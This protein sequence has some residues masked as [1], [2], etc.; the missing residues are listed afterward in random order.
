MSET[1]ELILPPPQALETLA[2]RLTEDFYAWEERG[3]GWKLHPY[4]IDLEPP[5]RP[6][7]FHAV[8][9][10]RVED[11][12]RRPTF[13]SR[14]ADSFLERFGK[15]EITPP[16]WDGSPYA[17]FIEPECFPAS[18]PSSIAEISVT[19][20]VEHEIQN[21]QKCLAGGF[22]TVVLVSSEPKVLARARDL[23]S[24]ALAP[25]TLERVRFLAPEDFLTFLETLPGVA[26]ERK[27]V[28]GYK[29]SVKLRALEERQ[30]AERKQAIAQTIVRAV[31]RLKG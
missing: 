17:Q 13:L 29:V 28:R 6:F 1:R 5:F 16:E 12:A 3:R 15:R 26:P 19:T 11:D 21:V 27:L 4:P 20:D 24:T 14:L 23:A 25:E 30:S 7:V 2:A 10:N 18:A 9:P 8:T 22:G 31:K